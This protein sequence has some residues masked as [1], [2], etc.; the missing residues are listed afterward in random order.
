MH[1]GKRVVFYFQ[2]WLS[3]SLAPN[4]HHILL[5]VRTLL[6]HES[7]VSYFCWSWRVPW[8]AGGGYSS[9]WGHKSWFRW[10]PP[11]RTPAGGRHPAWVLAFLYM[12]LRAGVRIKLPRFK[13]QLTS[14]TQKGLNNLP[15]PS[16]TPFFNLRSIHMGG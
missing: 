15:R 3:R 9:P 10:C 14:S 5:A 12:P 1:A 13:A 11:T 7:L 16:L 8:E 4:F 6:G 2:R